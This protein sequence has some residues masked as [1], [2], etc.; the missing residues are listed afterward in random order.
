MKI[1]HCLNRYS[2]THVLYLTN[3]HIIWATSTKL[4]IL[5]LYF[6]IK[7]AIHY[8]TLLNFPHYNIYF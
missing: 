3:Y 1:Q 4:Y 5:I 6:L 8:L 7:F 2:N